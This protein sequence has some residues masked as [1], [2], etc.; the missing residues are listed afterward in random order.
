MKAPTGKILASAIML[1]LGIASSPSSIA[2]NTGASNAPAAARSA[3]GQSASSDMRAS[4]LIGKQVQNAQGE[5]LGKIEDIVLDIDNERAS[6]V[7]LSSGGTLG[8]GDRQIAVPASGFQ[9]RSEKD[10]ILLNLPKDQL[11]KAPAYDKKQHAN[12]SRDSYRSEVDRYFF[13]EETVRHSAAGARLMSASDLIGK[14][15]N[16]RAA[17]DAGKIADVV[18]NLG[19]AGSYLVMQSDKAWSIDDKLVALPFAAFSFPSRPD[20]DLLLNVDRTKIESA[21][22]FQKNKWP[23]L[24]AAS[25]QQQI[26]EQLMTFQAA[27]KTNPGETQTGRETSSGGSR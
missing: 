21:R 14:D 26:R 27:S 3:T 9:V 11:Q 1:S 6:Y 8:V 10:P 24:N 12:F 15:I 19:S 7:V 20:L 16:D 2:Q 17:H 13:K 4:Q 25:A 23:D 18:V 22:G 5:K